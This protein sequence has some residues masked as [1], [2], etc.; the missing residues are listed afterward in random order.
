VPPALTVD[1]LIDRGVVHVV[2]FRDVDVHC[3]HTS[4]ALTVFLIVKQSTH[5]ADIL[6]LQFRLGVIFTSRCVSFPVSR[7]PSRGFDDTLH[8]RGWTSLLSQFKCARDWSRDVDLVSF[9][10]GCDREGAIFN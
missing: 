5:F 6:F 4:E 7:F 2:S 9:T 10:I 3:V 1:D 8:W